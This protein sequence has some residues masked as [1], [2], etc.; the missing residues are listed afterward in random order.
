MADQV[1]TAPQKQQA[2]ARTR[3]R[4]K[5]SDAEYQIA[6]FAAVEAPASN[7]DVLVFPIS[8]PAQALHG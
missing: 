6:A 4:M 5:P 8:S 2:A 1:F 7:A 3:G